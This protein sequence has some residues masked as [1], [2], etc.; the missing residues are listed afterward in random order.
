MSLWAKLKERFP[1]TMFFY[2]CGM[3][4]VIGAAILV[5]I[6]TT[7]GAEWAWGLVLGACIALPIISDIKRDRERR[8]DKDD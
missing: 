3:A 1:C 4:G 5:S 6:E 2:G 8:V 7:L